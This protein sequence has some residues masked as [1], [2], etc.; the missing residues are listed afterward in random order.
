MMNE[1][2][3]FSS[4]YFSKQSGKK[5]TWRHNLGHCIIKADFP[6]VL[7]YLLYITRKY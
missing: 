4:F 6:K 3:L 5:L 2:N 7:F 1:L